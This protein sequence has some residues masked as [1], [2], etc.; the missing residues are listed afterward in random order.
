MHLSF[1][2]VILIYSDHRQVSAAHVV[3]FRVVSER[4]QCDGI[5]AQL[6]SIIPVQMRLNFKQ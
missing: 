4:V 5:T 6:P 3:I 2:N 1:M